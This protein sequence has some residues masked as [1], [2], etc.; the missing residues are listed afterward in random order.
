M[1]ARRVEIGYVGNGYYRLQFRNEYGGYDDCVEVPRA[2]VRCY[3]SMN[4]FKSV[5]VPW[6]V[7]H[8][9]AATAP[10]SQIRMSSF[11]PSGVCIAWFLERRTGGA[12]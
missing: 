7:L 1:S 5:R 12:A 10:T 3:L 8:A 9:D 6:L 4:G 11:T 2:K